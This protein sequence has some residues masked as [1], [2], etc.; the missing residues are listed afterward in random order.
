[1]TWDSLSRVLQPLLVQRPICTLQLHPLK[2]SFSKLSTREHGQKPGLFQGVP[3][4]PN[5]GMRPV[6][7]GRLTYLPGSS[8]DTR[9]SMKEP[10]AQTPCTTRAVSLPVSW[11]TSHAPTVRSSHSRSCCGK[12]GTFIACKSPAVSRRLN[13]KKTGGKDHISPKDHIQS[14]SNQPVIDGHRRPRTITPIFT[15]LFGF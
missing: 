7:M 13:S 4:L 10:T 1:M 9:S 14:N 12:R 11:L 3:V 2:I 8:I 6:A 5:T 15:V